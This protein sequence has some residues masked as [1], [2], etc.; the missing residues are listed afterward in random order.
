MN[1]LPYNLIRSKRK[2]LS[3]QIKDG[4]LIVRAP[5]RLPK[6]DIDRFVVS[7][8]GWITDKLAQSQ[9][10]L[11]QQEAFG[12][13]YGSTVLYRGREHTIVAKEGNEM[14]I[15]G[16]TFY[17]PPDMSS[18]EITDAC[19]RLYRHL[20]KVH[21]K[22]RVA[23]ISQHMGVTPSTV[24]ITSAKTRWGSCSS[25][26]SVNF[27]WFLIMADDATIDYVIV[28]ELA[29]LTEMNHSKRFWAIVEGVMPDYHQHRDSLK[30]LQQRLATEN[31]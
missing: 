28:H 2:T 9:E 27:S 30:N 31:W 12:L 7:K 16:N 15:D 20:A 14:G 29:H 23:D 4:Q 19:K 10:R 8:R 22:K 25:K 13:T 21:I 5:L 1:M 3:L 24:R 6:A 11:W 26:K 18:D 17:M